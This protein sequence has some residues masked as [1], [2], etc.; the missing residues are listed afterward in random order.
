MSVQSTTL[1]NGMVVLTDDMPHLESASLGVWVKAG[2]RSERKNEH[3]I[4]HLLEHMAFKGTTSRTSLQIAEAIEN[5]GGDLNAAT[6]IEHTGYF[7]RVLKDDVVLAADILSDILQNSLFD[8]DELTR[9]KQVIV[10]EIGAA[11]DNPDDHVFDLFQAAAFP[12]QPIGRTILGTV[13]S[14]RDITSDT[15]RKYMNRNYVGD[16]MV[17]A[18]AGSVDHEGLVEVARERFADLK[19]NGA[20]APQRAEYQGGEERL[21]SE[22]EQA[23]IVIGF[24]GRAYNADGFYA[25]QVLASILGGGMSSRLFQEVREKRGLCYSVYS[26][27]WAFAD[28][29]VFGV[30][31]ATG[32]DEVADLVPVVLDE[33]KRATESITD[34]EVI[35]VRNQIR[36]GLLMSLESPSARA[37]QLARQQILWGRPIPMLETVER[38]NAITTQRVQEV[39][40]RIFTQGLPTV[41]GIGPIGNL[42]DL[43]AISDYLKR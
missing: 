8:E 42:P 12:T 4:S 20:P 28:S 27:H 39:A 25:A 29:G 2:A 7:A 19:L 10:Q 14:V 17:I 32:E 18:A 22:H 11:R 43:G 3:G 34:D 16:H 36:A 9:E 6:S 21:I 38:I 23:H 41:A 30:A 13:D 40:E 35:R 26:F 31:A 5:V 33:L 37:G 15:V 1:D 24:E